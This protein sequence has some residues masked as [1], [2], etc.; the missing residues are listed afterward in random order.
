ML[1]SCRYLV[2]KIC[3]DNNRRT[4][5][6]ESTIHKDSDKLMSTHAVCVC[7]DDNDLQ[8]AFACHHAY[9][10]G[11]SSASMGQAIQDNP[12]H[13]TLTGKGGGDSTSS[14]NSAVEGT[15]ATEIALELILERIMATKEGES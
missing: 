1:Y 10:P 2:K 13:F 3:G 12:D 5:D 9:I 8:M 4:G 6:K 15:K 11:I 7:D 14:D